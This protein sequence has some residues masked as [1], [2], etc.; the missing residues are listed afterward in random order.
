MRKPPG[1]STRLQQA[2]ETALRES[3]GRAGGRQSFRR[4]MTTRTSTDSQGRT[5]SPEQEEFFRNSAI[6]DKD[7]HL[8]VMYHATDA[9]FTVFDKKKAGTVTD[10][11][12]WGRGF[13]FDVEES[14]LP[15]VWEQRPP[16]IIST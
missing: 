1:D 3:A 7:G 2:V 10:G 15:W 14:L 6:R 11:G 5:L 16:R 4:S 13:Y 8:Q 12:I 9:Q